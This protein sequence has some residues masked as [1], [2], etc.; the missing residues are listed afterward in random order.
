VFADEEKEEEGFLGRAQ[1]ALHL[2]SRRLRGSK[3]GEHF[4]MSEVPL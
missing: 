1:L 3:G 2:L 4:L